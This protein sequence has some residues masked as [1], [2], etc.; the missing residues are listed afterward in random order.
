[1][2]WPTAPKLLHCTIHF[3]LLDETDS[4]LTSL[5]PESQAT[6]VIINSVDR[7]E[8]SATPV[9]I[10]VLTDLTGAFTTKPEPKIRL[11]AQ[12]MSDLK[13]INTTGLKAKMLIPAELIVS[14]VSFLC[15]GQW[16]LPMKYAYYIHAYVQTMLVGKRHRVVH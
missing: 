3:S 9:T 15:I 13:I 6:Y 2:I 16:T 7:M 4:D 5:E 8:I 11:M 10:S 1:M 12:E 14:S